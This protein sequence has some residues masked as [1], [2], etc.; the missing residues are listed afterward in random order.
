M[1]SVIAAERLTKFYGTT[2]GVEDLTFTVEPGEVFGFLGPNGAGK[3]TTIRTMLDLIRP[4][5][6][7]ITVM[8]MRPRDDAPAIHARIGYL[9]GELALYEKM[10]ALECLEAFGSF[11]GG[12]PR[13]RIET[14]AER[15]SLD[16]TKRIRSLSH[17]NKQKIGLVQAFVHEPE[18]LILDEPTQG[19][20]PLMQQEFYALIDEARGRGA[21]VFL[22]S[23]VMPEVERVCDR[24]AIIREGR[25]VTVADIGDLKAQALR[26][27]ELHFD[28]PVPLD[29]FAA[30]P[31]VRDAGSHGDVI[32]LTVQGVVDPVVKEAAKHT[33]VSIE[34]EEPSLEEIF[35]A[36]YRDGGAAR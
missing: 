36:I 18:L 2:R 30:L 21:S 10:T 9:P 28:G 29:A 31:S 16:L 34:S 17:G 6:G 19:L 20:D 15:L 27:L 7:D 25:L 12:V 35:L 33:V 11:R 1:S 14:F 13:G 4:T 8:G 24:V 22:S 3:T 23:H 26:R 5:A 32:R